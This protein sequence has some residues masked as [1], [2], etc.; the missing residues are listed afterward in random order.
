MIAGGREL[1][2]LFAH[3][4]FLITPLQVETAIIGLVRPATLEMI[5]RGKADFARR[6]ETGL[7]RAPGGVQARCLL[8]PV[9]EYGLRGA[10][11]GY[12]CK[13][14]GRANPSFWNITHK[15]QGDLLDVAETTVVLL[16]GRLAIVAVHA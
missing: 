6:G 15:A 13:A 3:S 14:C 12:R 11:V 10:H 4:S 8:Q 9:V 7:L 1:R 5:C 2:S 16:N